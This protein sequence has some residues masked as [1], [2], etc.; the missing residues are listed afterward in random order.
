MENA[1]APAQE[2]GMAIAFA[3]GSIQE[4]AVESVPLPIM[5]LTEMRINFYARV[6]MKPVLEPAKELVQQIAWKAARR[7]GV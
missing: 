2:K 1:K 4:R 7:G 5:N 6:A 3:I